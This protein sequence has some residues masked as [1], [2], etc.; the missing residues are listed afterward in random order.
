MGENPP[1][2]N[3]FDSVE[4]GKEACFQL[5]NKALFKNKVELNLLIIHFDFRR[6]ED[7]KNIF[8]STSKNLILPLKIAEKN[9]GMFDNNALE[10]LETCVENKKKN[11]NLILFVLP[12]KA[13]SKYPDIKKWC[14]SDQNHS[15]SSQVVLDSKLSNPK[16]TQTVCTKLLLQMAVKIGNILWVPQ[17]PKSDS[18][19]MIVAMAIA[20]VAESRNSVVA[21]NSTKDKLY[22]RFHSSYRYQ[23]AEGSTSIIEK[24]GEIVLECVK[25]YVDYNLNQYPDVV[26]VLREG[27]TDAQTQVIF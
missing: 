12:A 24:A 11:F 4:R 10:A 6:L 13:K 23:S 25:S 14:Y 15:V 2:S 16:S 26:I 7:V 22:S 19:I 27:S 9:L 20:K 21:Y 3:K 17:P 8:T 5:F 18:K 1:K